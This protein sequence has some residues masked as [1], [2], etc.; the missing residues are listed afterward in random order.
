MI[1]GS[2]RIVGSHTVRANHR[3]YSIA[4][5]KHVENVPPFRIPAVVAGVA[6]IGF[7]VSFGDILY[8][9]ENLW[10]LGIIALANF[11]APQI[12]RLKFISRELNSSQQG[13]V[14]WGHYKTL[15]LY[16]DQTMSLISAS[17]TKAS[18]EEL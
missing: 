4:N 3:S 16:R 18:H 1:L 9:H 12:G 15:D 2:F 11:I 17:D 6:A 10:T 13:N 8:L 7:L 5:L 14:I